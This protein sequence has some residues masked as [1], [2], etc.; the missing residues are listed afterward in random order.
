MTDCLEVCAGHLIKKHTKAIH[1]FMISCLTP[2][3]QS[4][5]QNTDPWRFVCFFCS[6]FFK[7]LEYGAKWIQTGAES[8]T[9]Q[10]GA[11]PDGAPSNLASEQQQQLIWVTRHGSPII[12]IITSHCGS[13]VTD[14]QAPTWAWCTFVSSQVGLICAAAVAA[15]WYL[16]RLLPRSAHGSA[17]LAWRHG[18][19]FTSTLIPTGIHSIVLALRGCSQKETPCRRYSPHPG[20]SICIT[21]FI[22]NM[23][24]NTHAQKHSTAT[25]I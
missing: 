8:T 21:L 15:G 3:K 12:I 22:F 25:A 23:Q 17:P 6:L 7:V 16:D 24:R 19:P 13:L 1:V 14:V 2:I 18:A 9:R 20:M 11:A 5:Q 4:E 10:S